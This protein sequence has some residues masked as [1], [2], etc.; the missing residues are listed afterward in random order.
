[1]CEHAIVPSLVEVLMAPNRAKMQL[2]VVNDV[3]S[4]S[5]VAAMET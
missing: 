5:P 2:V 3:S 1:M 4:V